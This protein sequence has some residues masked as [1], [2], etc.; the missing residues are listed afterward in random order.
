M[1][2]PSLAC[3]SSGA[4]L[5]DVNWNENKIKRVTLE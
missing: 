3:P 5:G 4:V 2:K 1:R